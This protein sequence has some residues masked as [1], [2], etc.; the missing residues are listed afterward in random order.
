VTKKLES[1]TFNP[2]KCRTELAAFKRLLESKEQLEEQKDIQKFFRRRKQLSAFIG[3]YAPDIGPAKLI[4][5]EFP[6]GGDFLA[7][8]V[9]GNKDTSTFCIVEFE[10]AKLNSIFRKVGNRSTTEWSPRFEH[11]FSQLVDWC[12]TLDDFKKTDR[13]ARDFGYGHVRF[14]ALLIVGRNAGVSAEDRKR[15]RWRTEK[16][17]VDSHTFECLTFDDLYEHLSMRISFYP[18][19]SQLENTGPE[20]QR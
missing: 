1:I 2:A 8:I 4:A 5:F 12:C 14:V 19:A 16:V 3:T 9:V 17:R 20:L 11:G 6:F 13:F 15:L 7:D 18:E 10:D